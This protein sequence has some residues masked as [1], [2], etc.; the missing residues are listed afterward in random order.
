MSEKIRITA[1]Q[2]HDEL[3][4]TF[5]IKDKIGRIEINLGGIS[6]T[7]GGRDAIGDLLQEWIGEWLKNN[8]YY[9]RTFKIR[10]YF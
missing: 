7:Y 6:A 10:K 4:N 2:L 3:L 8:N 9:F 1:N 5:K